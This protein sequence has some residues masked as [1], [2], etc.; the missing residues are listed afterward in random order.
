MQDDG[1]AVALRSP[2]EF[3]S[4]SVFF[5]KQPFS[6]IYITLYPSPAAEAAPSGSTASG[7]SQHLYGGA[8]VMH[9]AQSSSATPAGGTPTSGTPSGAALGT[10]MLG[11]HA[12]PI[13]ANELN[14]AST[15]ASPHFVRQMVSDAGS[16]YFEMG[17]PGMT[18]RVRDISSYP[19]YFESIR[20]RAATERALAGQAPGTFILRPSSEPGKL[21][22]AFVSEARTVQQ[23]RLVRDAAGHF[24]FEDAEVRFATIEE[25]VSVHSSVLMTPLAR[26]ARA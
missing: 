13:S 10:E 24:G 11:R 12:A 21:V 9:S 22:V 1:D 17:S 16:N 23:A 6:C 2:E 25:F 3:A 15:V 4:A 14:P 26:S 5:P 7:S 18:A 8:D 19:W 20:D